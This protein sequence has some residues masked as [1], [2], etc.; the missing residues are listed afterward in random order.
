MTESR[1]AE[2]FRRFRATQERMSREAAE[3]KAQRE[4][5][6]ERARQ[7]WPRMRPPWAQ[8]EPRQPSG[9]IEPYERTP[10]RRA[11]SQIM[12]EDPFAA[13]RAGRLYRSD[14]LGDLLADDDA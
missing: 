7:R 13:D 5:E 2:A 10:N 11:H 3:R 12:T 4:A 1:T 8:R 9:M 14:G 6:Q